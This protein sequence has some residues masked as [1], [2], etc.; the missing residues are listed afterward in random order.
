[1]EVR[2][3]V[4]LVELKTAPVVGLVE[5]LADDSGTGWNSLIFS[6][7]R[8]TL[9]IKTGTLRQ[10]SDIAYRCAWRKAGD[11]EGH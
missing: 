11:S 4:N 9:E 10:A 5:R 3:N 2:F 8:N 7:T 6:A 1:M